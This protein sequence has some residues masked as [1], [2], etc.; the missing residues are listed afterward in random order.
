MEKIG[1]K[2]NNLFDAYRL[3]NQGLSSSR[4]D[5]LAKWHRTL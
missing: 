5:N 3:K 1:F 2:Y 4:E